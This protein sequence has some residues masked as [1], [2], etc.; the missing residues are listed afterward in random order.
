M[1]RVLL[2]DDKE[3]FLRTIKRMPFFQK[4]RDRVQI[5][6]TACSAAEAL[7]I[8]RGE[9]V[10][11]VMTDIRMPMMSGIDLLKVIRKEGLCSCT[12]L[13]SEYTEF[14]YAREGI[15]YGAFDYIV[16]PL[17]DDTVTAAMNRALAFL[18]SLDA[19]QEI[20]ESSADDLLR[21]ILISDGKQFEEHLQRLQD[22]LKD[23]LQQV[24]LAG[25]VRYV[26]RL[27]SLILKSIAMDYAH[28]EKYLP[29]Q[30]LFTL[31][32]EIGDTDAEDAIAYLMKSI[33]FLH[34]KMALFQLD[35]ENLQVR[36][37]WYYTIGSSDEPC[38]LSE[39]AR[40]FFL[41]PSY[42]SSLFKKETG[43]SYKT[44]VQN[45]KME[46]ARYLLAFS[47]KKNAEI[48]EL[49]NFTDAEYFRKTF[50]ASTGV[51]PARFDYE[52]YIRMTVD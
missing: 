21:A 6:W 37:I 40:R 49:L 30:M 9:P 15:L 44:F 33:R 32:A 13:V 7:K 3:I 48:A 45:L 36:N 22:L 23:R 4:Y 16:K 29:L 50:K 43:V 38:R 10:D 27:Q 17:E 47:G 39:T 14:S 20:R 41:N 26:Q 8:L 35:S 52:E 11:I 1:F 46:R 24:P 19:G 34:K 2:V 31:P 42:L 12:I 28:I 25:T 5:A 51:S 18:Q